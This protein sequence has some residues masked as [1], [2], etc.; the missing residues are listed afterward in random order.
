NCNVDPQ[1]TGPNMVGAQLNKCT[2]VFHLETLGGNEYVAPGLQGQ[3]SNEFILGAEYEVLPDIKVGLNYIHRDLPTIIED[4]LV[5]G[6]NYYIVNPGDNFDSQA[7]SLAKTAAA[8]LTSNNPATVAQ[9]ELDQARSQNL[10]QIKNLDTPTR[11][12]DAVQ[13]QVT[14]RPTKDS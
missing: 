8:E 10:T 1:P 3:Y 6:G 9:G 14:Q 11:N 5:N 4:T 12:Y 13:L 2:D 7:A